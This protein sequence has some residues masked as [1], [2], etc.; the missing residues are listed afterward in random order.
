M[1]R[2]LIFINNIAEYKGKFYYRAT[3][4]GKTRQKLAYGANSRKDAEKM[5]K[6]EQRKMELEQAG[7]IKPSTPVPL[8]KLCQLYKTHSETNNR[9]KD[10]GEKRKLIQEFWGLNKDDRQLK[11]GDI[12]KWRAWLRDTKKLSNAT[13][14]KYCSYLNVAYKLAIL[15]GLL[16]NNP[17]NFIK[18]LEE[19][20]ENIKYLTKKEIQ[21]FLTALEDFPQ[22]KSII[23]FDI[24]TGFRIGNVNYLRWEWID[25]EHRQ[26][27]IKPQ[28]N[29]GGLD[30]YHQ[31][32]DEILKIF[33]EIGIK[34]TGYVFPLGKNGIKPY[35][36]PQRDTINKV[37]KKAGI[38]A[39]GFHIL[40][41]TAGTTLAE[42]NIP[43]KDIQAF[44]HH[45]D[46]RTSLKYTHSSNY[47]QSRS[48]NV[49][50]NFISS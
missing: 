12:E 45:K 17:L 6:E 43:F 50:Q 16:E 9:S 49:M 44:L 26:I 48:D 34:K 27:H 31:I 3:V 38:D 2:Q 4:R 35:A 22:F 39:S 5:L 11:R 37:F 1:A 29:K 25:I 40:R 23:L 28:D 33:E 32:S 42:N 30:I 19:P 10:R 21:R 47:S 7:L 18:K 13:I 20:K 41:H 24:L 46:P 8:S 15:D 36:N 14:N